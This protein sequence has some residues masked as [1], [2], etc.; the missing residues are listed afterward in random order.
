V[1][2]PN[3][4]IIGAGSTI[5]HTKSTIADMIHG[6]RF[7]I[8]P[9][10]NSLALL[11]PLAGGSNSN[12]AATE[13]LRIAEDERTVSGDDQRRGR[14]RRA[15]YFGP[16]QESDRREQMIGLPGKMTVG[17]LRQFFES[18]PPVLPIVIGIEGAALLFESPEKL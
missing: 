13:R 18:L 11:D 9:P 15:R 16:I 8:D 7:G 3:C 1:A 6:N 2:C 12:T 17:N 5:A 10:F 14:D 4:A